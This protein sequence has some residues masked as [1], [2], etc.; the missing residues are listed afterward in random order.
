MRIY[1][2]KA[3]MQ[4]IEFSECGNQSHWID[5]IDKC[6]WRAGTFLRQLLLENSLKE[7]CG[8]STRLL[9]L[10]DGDK[11]VSFCTLAETDDIRDTTLTPWIGF[12]YT[13]PEYRGHRYFGLLLE[14]ACEIAKEDGHEYI[15][16]STTEDGL[17]EKYGFEFQSFMKDSGGE[18]SKVYRL[19]L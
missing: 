16:I 9:L 14:R 5:E 3:V 15:Y 1:G 7:F 17:Y 12:V 8:E 10:T 6:D 2:D 18:D 13:Y 4:I 11:L 19:G